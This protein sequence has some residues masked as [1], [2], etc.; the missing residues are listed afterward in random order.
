MP[1]W[2]LIAV[3]ASALVI[4]ICC[5]FCICKRCCKKHKKLKKKDGKE[6]VQELNVGNSMK[7]RIRRFSIKEMVQPNVVELGVDIEGDQEAD[8]A[9]PEGYCGKIQLSFDFDFQ[10][11]EL[12]VCVLQAND[13]P[14]MDMN[15]LSDPYIKVT[16]LPEKKKKFETKVKRKT[17]NP[18]F[19]ETFVFKVPYAEVALKT[20]T[21][22]V[23][24]FDRFSKH[25][26]IGHLEIP[27]NTIDFGNSTEIW[28]DLE[29]PEINEKESKLGDICFSLRYKPTAKKLTVTILE[30]KNLKKMDVGGSADPY[31]KIALYQGNKRLKKKKTTVKN[32]ILN[33]Y[34]NES[35]KF[36]VPPH[37]IEKINLIIT[38]VDYDVIGNSDPI[39][40]VFLGCNSSGSALRHWSDML[41][42]PRRPIAQWHT[43][44][45]VPPKK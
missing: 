42:N 16:L 9:E 40:R 44:Q 17:L 18:V 30:A 2:V 27:L 25:D 37:Q 39:G 43:L 10:K 35:F 21:F 32:S 12:S 7:E 33:P 45:E 19:N 14:G 6:S 5:T 1:V 31:V 34:Y 26:E 24:D 8:N 3:C 28:Y 11:G 23:Y 13:L 38:V 15:G 29:S 36:D 20:V 22:A 41:A 4:L